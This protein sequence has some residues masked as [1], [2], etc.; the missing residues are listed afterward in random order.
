MYLHSFLPE[1]ADLNWWNDGVRD[2]FDGILRFWLDRGVAGFRLDRGVAGFRL[3]VAH[4][5]VKDR[6]LRDRPDDS[7]ADVFVDLEETLAVLQRWQR[8]VDAYEGPRVLLGETWVMDIE[9]LMGFYGS[10]E[11][12]LHLAFN[13]PFAL[14]PLEAEPLRTIVET[15]EA[16]LPAGAWPPRTLATSSGCRRWA[17][18]QT[19]CATLAA[20]TGR[21]RRCRGTGGGLIRGCPSAAA[22]QWLRSGRIPSRSSRTP[23]S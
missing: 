9:R 16:A 14:S 3:D 7:E 13:F 4:A 12:R 19:Q 8:V 23:V 5:V 2:E 22:R 1:Q 17:C 6:E 20:A 18:H 15:T 11:D 21:G 10:G